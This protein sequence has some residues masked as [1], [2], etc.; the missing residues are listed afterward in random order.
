MKHIHHYISTGYTITSIAKFSHC[1]WLL[2]RYYIIN[3]FER[4]KIQFLREMFY[5]ALKQ[6][7]DVNIKSMLLVWQLYECITIVWKAISTRKKERNGK[8]E[9]R[10][11][12]RKREGKRGWYWDRECFDGSVYQIWRFAFYVQRTLVTCTRGRG[13]YRAFHLTRNRSNYTSIGYVIT[14]KIFIGAYSPFSVRTSASGLH[15]RG[16]FR[17]SRL[18]LIHSC[19]HIARA[20]GKETRTELMAILN[21]PHQVSTLLLPP[22]TS[23]LAIHARVYTYTDTQHTQK[24]DDACMYVCTASHVPARLD[25][26]V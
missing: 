8:V 22:L 23:L 14:Q 13:V 18:G 17:N 15:F 19:R 2:S 10:E 24:K 21:F 11:G 1:V 25:F 9:K 4:E 5:Q 6:H 3:M 16:N 26:H 20:S 12:D 7:C